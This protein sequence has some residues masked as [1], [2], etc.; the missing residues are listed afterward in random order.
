MD[1][2]QFNMSRELFVVL[3][4]LKS[5]FDRYHRRILPISAAPAAS[6]IANVNAFYQEDKDLALICLTFDAGK[7]DPFNFETLVHLGTE[8][9][10]S[11]IDP[12]RF[13]DADRGFFY[14]D[15][16]RRFAIIATN[17]QSPV[18]ALEAAGR[19]LGLLAGTQD[20]QADGEVS[21]VAETQEQAPFV[22][23]RR[24][25]SDRETLH[26][27]PTTQRVPKRTQM[28]NI[29]RTRATSPMRVDEAARA[30]S[31]SQRA[32]E[33][34]SSE[35]VPVAD[36][37]SMVWAPPDVTEFD[38]RRPTRA[39]SSEGWST[40]ELSAEP[41][42]DTQDEVAVQAEQGQSARGKGKRSQRLSTVP[43]RPGQRPEKVDSGIKLALPSTTDPKVPVPP[44]ARPRRLSSSPLFNPSGDQ[45]RIRVRYQRGDTWMPGR[46][47]N[48]TTKDIRL[49][50]SAA[51]PAG[52]ILRV[53][54]T[55]G[56]LNAV[57]TGTVV[58]VINAEGSTDGS[59]T[60]RCEFRRVGKHEHDRLVALLRQAKLAGMSLT[61]PPP[62]RGRRFAI[63]WPMAIKN[64]GHR[65]N[66][67]ALDISE[68]GLF[69][70]T[71][72]LL[73]STNLLFGLPLDRPGESVRGRA[74]V[75]R[76]VSE[77]MARTRG[78]SLGY[79]LEIE[80][81]HVQDHEAYGEFL[82]R[83]KSRSQRHVLVAGEGERTVALADCLR[84]A[85]YAVSKAASV[86]IM[87]HRTQFES[88]APDLA[89]MDSGSLSV[90]SQ[91][92]FRS[93]F[94]DNDVPLVLA[95]DLAPHMAREQV[96]QMVE[97]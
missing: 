93:A 89:L 39:A 50:A 69:V 26:T 14:Q 40:A 74:K 5:R 88:N 75:A 73:R 30:R 23:A 35:G 77:H 2:Q 85:G 37:I 34:P 11:V 65:F 12:E 72:T 47:R 55:I 43:L 1:P 15:Y 17:S 9:G 76:K 6:V 10:F 13:T 62:R 58:E 42:D 45:E 49:A 86:E 97:I 81:F 54:V 4:D 68:H 18:A 29:R 82:Q 53:S 61:A 96:D 16:L 33:E 92:A 44:P 79:G 63:S 41:S 21:D 8:A 84:S 95:G 22:P 20:D 48:L 67:S 28:S 7:F 83:V 91:R 51:P 52:S 46:L 56:D 38:Y 70:S 64:D 24:M 90:D 27:L 94:R 32:T 31:G 59:T 71:T 66:A 60:F 3:R 19:Q 78:L 25:G 87:M 57:V 36:D 80:E